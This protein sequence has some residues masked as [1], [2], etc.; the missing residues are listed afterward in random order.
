MQTL[1]VKTAPNELLPQQTLGS[2]Y[3][4]TFQSPHSLLFPLKMPSITLMCQQQAELCMFEVGCLR[5]GCR[6]S[7]VHPSSVDGSGMLRRAGTSL[8]LPMASFHRHLNILKVHCLAKTSIQ[9]YFS[10][11]QP[12]AGKPSP[13]QVT[14][15]SA[16]N[17]LS[18]KTG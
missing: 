2:S 17:K 10:S 15:S 5:L 16:A 3:K 12:H 11:H 1:I 18:C 7:S 13:F 8:V 14:N 9:F 6:W 4:K